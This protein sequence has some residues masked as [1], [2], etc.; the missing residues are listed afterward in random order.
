MSDE[1]PEDITNLIGHARS[2]HV[3]SREQLARWL[4]AEMRKIAAGLLRARQVESDLS[5]SILVQEAM[6]RLIDDQVMESAPNRR[7]LIGASS[8]SMKHVL[9]DMIRR[10]AALKRDSGGRRVEMTDTEDR[11][12]RPE[13]IDVIAIGEA[14]DELFKENERQALLVSLRFFAGLSMNEIA[15]ALDVSL[16]T[17]EGDWR[18]ARAWLRARLQ[19]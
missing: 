5:P 1:P 9:V 8:L 10:K 14:V 19:G 18:A 4:T 16:A 6:V 2:G 11:S 7:Y 15:D 13:T 3:E 17:I 12:K